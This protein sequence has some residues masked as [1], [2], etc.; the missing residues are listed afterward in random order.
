M[1][2]TNIDESKEFPEQLDEIVLEPP[3]G[4]FDFRLR[5]LWRFR[6]LLYFLVWRDLKVRYKQTAL[7]AAWAI[8]QPFMTMVIFS[9]IFG[10]LA[11]LPT[12][13]IP[14]PIFSYTALL[15]W[16]LFSRALT[17]ASTSLVGNQQFVTK[18]YFPRLFCQFPQF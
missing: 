1:N 8:I 5:E 14:Y 11:K 7:G 4:W 9:V 12:D 3:S 10:S 2:D 6:E 13:G 15:P 17:D 16:Q 18:I